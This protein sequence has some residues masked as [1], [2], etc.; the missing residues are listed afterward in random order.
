MT[1]TDE[2]VWI[3]VPWDGGDVELRAIGAIMEVFRRAKLD[4]ASISSQ[5][6]IAVYFAERLTEQIEL[7]RTASPPHPTETEGRV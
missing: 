1:E 4:G 6:R 7:I 5:R 3:E 2:S